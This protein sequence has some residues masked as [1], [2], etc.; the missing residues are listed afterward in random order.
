MSHLQT[1]NVDTN[2]LHLLR[3][4]KILILGQLLTTD[5]CLP[6]EDQDDFLLGSTEEKYPHFQNIFLSR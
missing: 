4:P 3:A 1:T 2:T 6:L 5:F